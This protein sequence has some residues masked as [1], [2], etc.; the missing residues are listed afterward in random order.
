MIDKYNDANER[1]HTGHEIYFA[2][3]EIVIH[4]AWKRDAPKAI[5]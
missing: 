4:H 3:G 2:F 1:R 5:K